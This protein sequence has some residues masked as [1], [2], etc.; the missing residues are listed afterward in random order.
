MR[1]EAMNETFTER[2]KYLVVILALSAVVKHLIQCILH[3]VLGHL[4]DT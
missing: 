4:F 1:L 3:N 2:Y